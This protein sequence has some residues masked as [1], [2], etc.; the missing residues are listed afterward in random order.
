LKNSKKE[1]GREH[2]F[3]NN[4]NLFCFAKIFHIFGQ[5]IGALLWQRTSGFSDTAGR[6]KTLFQC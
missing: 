2:I 4:E 5:E 1:R 6:I 3:Y